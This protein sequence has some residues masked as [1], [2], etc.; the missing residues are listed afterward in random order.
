MTVLHVAICGGSWCF[1]YHF[2]LQF[3]SVQPWASKTRS[4]GTAAR[5][6]SG[7]HHAPSIHIALGVLRCRVLA[8]VWP[9]IVRGLRSLRFVEC[10]GAEPHDRVPS[11]C[12]EI[13]LGCARFDD[14]HGLAWSCVC[15]R[16]LHRFH[17]VFNLG[18]G[19]VV[20]LSTGSDVGNGT[21]ANGME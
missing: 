2:Q 9:S 15:L 17:H 1:A 16:L 14:I 5:H 20:C 13:V 12:S 10:T 21:G 3:L 4:Q 7:V 11:G 6:P 19:E 18:D 8:T